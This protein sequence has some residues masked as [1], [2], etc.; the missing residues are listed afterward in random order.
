[1]SLIFHLCACF[2][3][4]GI[5]LT[6]LQEEVTN[7]FVTIRKWHGRDIHSIYIDILTR[8]KKWRKLIHN[9]WNFVADIEITSRLLIFICLNF[10]SIQNYIW[11]FAFI[12]VAD[13]SN[14]VIWLHIKKENVSLVVVSTTIFI[15]QLGAFVLLTFQLFSQ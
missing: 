15:S 4:T 8:L 9:L 7:F 6:T 11:S 12:F 1:M 5:N 2:W 3:S 13:K 10:F 14:H